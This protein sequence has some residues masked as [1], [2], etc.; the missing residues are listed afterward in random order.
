LLC[1]LGYIACY[2]YRA[3]ELALYIGL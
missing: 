2:V 1:I 3:I